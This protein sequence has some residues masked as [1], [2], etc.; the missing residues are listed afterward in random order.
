[1]KLYSEKL[2]SFTYAN[3]LA[4]HLYC[5]TSH[6]KMSLWKIMQYKIH[7][8]LCSVKSLSQYTAEVKLLYQSFKSST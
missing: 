7:A 4:G 5:S 6:L 3:L 2:N 1:M 8:E